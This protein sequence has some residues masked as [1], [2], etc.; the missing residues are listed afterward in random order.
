MVPS[1]T[2]PAALVRQGSLKLYATSVTVRELKLPG[3]Y[4]INKLDPDEDGPG[5]Q[6]LLNQG[7]AKKLTDYLLDGHIEGDA[8]L[9]TSLFLATNK[10]IHF[11]PKTNS[12]TFDVRDVGPFNVVDGQ[13]RIAGL[14][15]AAEKNPELLAFEVP[16]NIA[17]CLDD[18]SQMCHF[19]IVNTTQRSVDKA[20]EQQIVARLSGMVNIE[21]MPTIPRWIRRQVEKGEDARALFVTNFLNT[22]QNSPWLNK[23][24]MANDESADATINQKSFVNSVKKYIFSANNPL[25][26]ASFDQ[27]RPKMLSNYWKAI[28]ELL[29]DPE[30]PTSSVIFKTN[31]VDLFHISSATVFL[32]LAN[33]RD[34]RKE[35][36]KEVLTRG[37]ANLSGES[38]GMSSPEWWQ[39]GGV[40]S[41]LNSAGV[42]KLAN[43]LS[44]AINVQDGGGDIVL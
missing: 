15:A 27:T 5:F 38:I 22:D 32:Y 1:I 8:F 41:G 19:L 2:R 39:R 9:P 26:D 31:G 44:Q 29:V 34:F 17:V 23:I 16:I 20:V 10:D 43:A 6:R 36:I 30:S 3:F 40:A 11:D 18:V 24:R 28:V 33:K 14:V 42:R 21:D 25:A 12:I 37:F 4:Q 7:R 35:T 13:H